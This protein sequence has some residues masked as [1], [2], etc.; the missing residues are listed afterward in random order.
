MQDEFDD[1]LAADMA[2]IS[3]E[4]AQQRAAARAE[5]APPPPSPGPEQAAA[6]TP[7]TAQ[8]VVAL[9]PTFYC[10]TE[11]HWLQVSPTVELQGLRGL[12][13][14]AQA[15]YYRLRWM[16]ACSPGAKVHIDA[17]TRTQAA[18]GARP[19]K[20]YWD[21]LEKAGKVR[22][23]P[24]GH[25][26]TDDMPT[27]LHRLEQRI[28]DASAG[29]RAKRAKSKYPNNSGTTGAPAPAST[30]ADT[31]VR[32]TKDSLSPI[33]PKN[34]R[35][36]GT[37]PRAQLED[38]NSPDVKRRTLRID[39]QAHFARRNPDGSWSALPPDKRR[40]NEMHDGPRPGQRGCR[41]PADLVAEVELWAAQLP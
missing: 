18:G 19:F 32:Q 20:R 26:Q 30:G 28:S 10:R 7:E 39:L 21:E 13:L 31:G 36:H 8:D 29:G 23:L 1:E 12:S 35:A 17:E 37:N 9:D 34:S 38:P 33:V 6:P 5:V 3:A 40:W 25:G 11:K 15:V 41:Y 22:L 14:G 24:G 16:C 2:R 4:R 27:T